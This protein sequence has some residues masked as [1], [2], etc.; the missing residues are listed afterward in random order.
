MVRFGRVT[1]KVLVIGGTRYLGRQL[2]VDLSV[3]GASVTVLSRNQG[4]VPP[5]VKSLVSDR[6]TFLSIG[7]GVREFDYVIDLIAYVK[8]D[9]YLAL[10]KFPTAN[11]L[12][13]SSTWL[14]QKTGAPLAN[15]P[16]LDANSVPL[17]LPTSTQLYLQGKLHCERE[18][19]LGRDSGLLAQILRL[20]IL[21]GHR[22]HTKRSSFYLT[23]ARDGQ[24]QILIDSGLN[25]VQ[26]V[27][28]RDLSF[29]LTRYILNRTPHDASII[30]ALPPETVTVRDIAQASAS[31]CAM[32][33]R[34]LFASHE[35]LQQELA[36]YVRIEPLWRERVM[37]ISSGN[38]FCL[39]ES[40]PADFVTSLRELFRNDQRSQEEGQ[41]IRGELS[42][43]A[44][45]LR[46]GT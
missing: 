37:A 33:F 21:F 10:R 45:N 30:E 6:N 46:N 34:P 32:P 41:R 12:L 15:Q 23:R 19:L 17:D 44:A 14:P 18:T 16:I 43:I 8:G 31:I 27:W 3:Q 40:K 7:D 4:G 1:V 11:Y 26:V 38:L 13:I 42:F 36:G 28:I 29:A 25:D 39:T 35:R 24:G 5:G 22:D 2:A 20:P 9:A